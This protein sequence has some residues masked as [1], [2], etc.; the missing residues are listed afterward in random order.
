MEVVQFG[1]RELRVVRDKDWCLPVYCDPYTNDARTVTHW[2][3]RPAIELLADPFMELSRRFGPF[4]MCES[5]TFWVVLA[6]HMEKYAEKVTGCMPKDY[7]SWPQEGYGK[8]SKEMGIELIQEGEDGFLKFCL[9]RACIDLPLG[10]YVWRAIKEGMQH[11]LINY[12]KPIEFE[13]FTL[14]PLPYRHNWKEI[15]L[16]KFPGSYKTIKKSRGRWMDELQRTGFI[17]E[18][19]ST[20]L[21]S[22]N[23]D[24]TFNWTLEIM[25][26]KLWRDSVRDAEKQ[27]LAT[28]KRIKYAN[29]YE[30]C[31]HKRLND[32]ISAFGAWVREGTNPVAVL[33]ES[34]SSSG[35]VLEPVSKKK[36]VSPNRYR[37]PT[38]PFQIGGTGLGLVQGQQR[39]GN[40]LPKALKQMHDLSSVSH[41][42]RDLRECEG[43]IDVGGGTSGLLLSDEN[44]IQAEGQR[45]LAQ[46][47]GAQS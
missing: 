34:L 3:V 32:I 12:Q 43:P 24:K 5:T 27:R 2:M 21:I 25:P 13:I 28:K 29:Y 6:E 20:D 45:L 15:Q 23:K 8:E 46:R 47:E 44:E 26:T 19:G 7:I 37:P 33:R 40:N 10:K 17:Q 14:F 16:S 11:W 18:L 41:T 31:L 38:T 42:V 39:G 36:S 9:N 35:F 4:N 22:M 30:S 1:P